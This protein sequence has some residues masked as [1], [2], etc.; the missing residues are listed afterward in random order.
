MSPSV[1]VRLLA[2]QSDAR[3]VELARQGHERAFEALVQRYRRPL[4]AY[5]RRVLLPEARAEDAVQQTLL[6]AWLA[7]QRGTEVRDVRPWLYR[8][9]HNTA[10]NALRRSSYDYAEL[11]EALSGADAPQEDLDRRIAV[12]EALAGL[13]ALPEQQREALMRTAVEGASHADA[14]AEM[15]LSET[16]VRGLV[17]RARNT[18]RTALTAITPLPLLT[19]MVGHGGGAGAGAGVAVGG[20]SAGTVGL[21]AKSAAIIVTASAVAAGAET[22]VVHTHHRADHA[23]SRPAD[24][25]RSVELVDTAAGHAEANPPVL[26][27]AAGGSRHRGRHRQRHGRGHQHGAL[28]PGAPSGTGQLPSDGEDHGGTAHDH[29]RG[30]VGNRVSHGPS[31]THGRSGSHAHRGHGPQGKP[32]GSLPDRAGKQPGP[33]DGGGGRGASGGTRGSGGSDQNAGSGRSGG[34]SGA[35]GDSTGAGG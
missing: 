16:A 24:N 4:L 8:I 29:G 19:W 35:D 34:D 3:L 11:S 18:M 12:R 15:G 14:A 30:H 17:Y 26:P 21:L 32:R 10:V 27:A 25:A 13:A 9:A 6:Q 1:T 7:L 23:T 2:T 22:V 28:D 31:G 5:C 20:G 33:H